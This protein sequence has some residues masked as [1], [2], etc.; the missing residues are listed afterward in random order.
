MEIAIVKHMNRW[1]A[2]F[3]LYGEENVEDL[4]L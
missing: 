4:Q 2:G 3:V 1:Q